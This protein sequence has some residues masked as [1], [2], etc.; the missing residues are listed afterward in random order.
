[1]PYLE[2][3][4]DATRSSIAPLMSV[5][6]TGFGN[7]NEP[8]YS[9]GYDNY[10]NDFAAAAA[11]AAATAAAAAA[12]AAAATATATASNSVTPSSS[13]T[14]FLYSRG[15]TRDLFAYQ[16][17]INNR[18]MEALLQQASLPTSSSY[19]LSSLSSFL[20]GLPA[21]QQNNAR[22]AGSST[23]DYHDGVGEFYE[24]SDAMS[25]LLGRQANNS[26]VSGSFLRDVEA[27]DLRSSIINNAYNSRNQVQNLYSGSDRGNNTTIGAIQNTNR[28]DHDYNFVPNVFVQEQSNNSRSPSVGLEALLRNCS[29]YQNIQTDTYSTSDQ[30]LRANE[31][32]RNAD[33]RTDRPFN[34]ARAA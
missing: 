30:D 17:E 7:I 34:F 23:F 10:H 13:A 2:T 6:G 1:M 18:R 9:Q 8:F 11:A 28:Y 31:T 19:G 15:N 33:Q 25:G 14:S 27:N 3:D 5:A 22:Q 29:G 26:T 32:R 20:S 12:A 4:C 21:P 16:E 24:S